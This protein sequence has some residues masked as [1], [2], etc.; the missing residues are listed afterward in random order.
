MD[1][2]VV[3]RRAS[4]L[5]NESMPNVLVRDL[6]VEV[7]EVL[8]ARAERAGMSLQQYLVAELQRLAGSPTLEEVFERVGRRTGGS[9]DR[10][11]MLADLAELRGR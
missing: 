9:I 1:G 10:A 3:D 11:E 2:A 5:Q 4:R 6:P 7:H 8:R